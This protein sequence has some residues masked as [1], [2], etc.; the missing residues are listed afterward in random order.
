[1]LL[2]LTF[3]ATAWSSTALDPATRSLLNNMDCVAVCAKAL[4]VAL[5]QALAESGNGGQQVPAGASFVCDSGH[6][7][8][9]LW[10]TANC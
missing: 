10:R 4:A 5:P 3:T 8:L 1:M 9:A 6:A 2:A 7:F